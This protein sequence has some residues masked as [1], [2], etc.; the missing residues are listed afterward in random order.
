MPSAQRIDASQIRFTIHVLHIVNI[1]SHYSILSLVALL[2]FVID[3]GTI[4]GFCPDQDSRN[5]RPAQLFIDP[6]LNF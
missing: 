4:G 1:D 6:F 3:V 5:R 2:D